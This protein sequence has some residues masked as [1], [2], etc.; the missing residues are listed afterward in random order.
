MSFDNKSAEATVTL[1]FVALKF[2]T[3]HLFVYK[4]LFFFS[5]Q[6]FIK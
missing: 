1:Q 3:L 2:Y 4:P 5:F 6:R